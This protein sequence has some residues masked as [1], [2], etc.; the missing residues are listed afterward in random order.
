MGV[1]GAMPDVRSLRISAALPRQHADGR[2]RGA[3]GA[4][5][6]AHARHAR[7][8][9]G[10]DGRRVIDGAIAACRHGAPADRGHVPRD[11]DRQL[12]GP[13]RHP[14]GASRDPE[15]AYRLRGACGFSFGNG[16]SPTTNRQ[17]VLGGRRQAKTRR[18]RDE[19]PA[20]PG[21]PSA[22]PTAAGWSTA[23]R[24]RNDDRTARRGRA[25]TA[26]GRARPAV[27]RAADGRSLRTCRNATGCLF[28]RTR[29]CCRC[30]CSST[31]TARAATAAPTMKSIC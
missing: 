18:R 28:D 9:A 10:Q 23:R 30:T 17:P 13:L 15:D 27:R 22:Y 5:P 1:D 11:G 6:G 19:D 7:L 21:G 24:D 29:A 2:R 20:R 4:R 8:H 31:F 14:D 12:R 25:R 3:G 26:R 16:C